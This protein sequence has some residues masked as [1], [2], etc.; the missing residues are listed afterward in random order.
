M[1]NKNMPLLLVILLVSGLSRSVVAQDMGYGRVQMN[2]EIVASACGIHTDDLWQEIHFP[3]ISTERVSSGSYQVTR[4][5][6]LRLINCRLE[7]E[8]GLLWHGARI[9]FDGEPDNR[10]QGL[11]GLYGEAQGLALQL[12]DVRGE[13]VSPGQ[14]FSTIPLNEG[15][16]Q[17][18]YHLRVMRNGQTLKEG[19]WSASL[20]FMVVYQ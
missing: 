19:A 5:F 6:S 15:D 9:Y 3:P 10:R 4:D 8:D 11:F 17:L 14:A 2:G 18:N 1:L 16:Q 12:S 20:R 13:I 7:K